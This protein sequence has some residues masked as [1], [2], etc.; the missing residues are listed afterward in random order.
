[1]S[2]N[3]DM[4]AMGPGGAGETPAQGSQG[5]GNA[6]APVPTDDLIG[7]DAATAVAELTARLGAPGAD[8]ASALD[9]GAVEAFP[10]PVAEAAYWDDSTVAA[11]MGPVGSGKTTT[12]LKS[13]LRRAMMMPRSVINGVRHYK[14]TV[15]A[16]TYRKL[17]AAAIK[18]FVDIYPKH[19]GDWSG[20]RGGPVTFVM[21]FDEG[22]WFPPRADFPED[23]EWLP[24]RVILEVEFMAFG[25]D[26]EEAIRGLQTTDVWMPE[27]D[28]SPGEV[29]DNFMTRINRH[30]KSDHK[31]GY[32]PD[33]AYYGQIVGDFNAPDP[34]NWTV[35]LL[36][37]PES[38]ARVL[39]AIN[40]ALP[41][42]AKP[43]NFSFYRQPGYGE[44]GCENLRNLAPGYYEAFIASQT[45]QGKS[46][47]IARLI[48]N[49]I[50]HRRAGE[51]VFQAE[52]N[53][54]IHIAGGALLPEPGVPLR[55]G[56]DQG[57][58]AA[59]VVAQFIGPFHWRILAE[60]HLP[61]RHMLAA[62]FGR[63]LRDLI[64]GRFPGFRVEG[65]WGDMAGEA[66]SSL[67]T[68]DVA[69]W[70]LL[71]GRAA[72]IRVRPQKVGANRIQPRLEAVRAALEYLHQG[73]PGLLID[74]SC[75]F[76]MAGFEARY[77]WTEETDASGGRRKV[78]DKR[79]TEANV[80]D[81][82][83]YLLLSEH[84]GLGASPV[85]FPQGKMALLGH[86]RGRM[87]PEPAGGLRTGFDVLNPHGG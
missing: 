18:D 21:P 19:L 30:P 38:R 5:A 81:A 66:G 78:P 72:G 43:I 53:P 36:M 87:A 61:D 40:Q 64:D 9:A 85:S 26:I 69:T 25:D 58:K 24:Q 84:R 49:R 32:P 44:P 52:F 31:K 50:T 33:Q 48:Y 39:A 16:P 42:G 47:T 34:D 57:F 65:A 29:F 86:D 41:A 83:Q 8:I 56:L 45:L 59:A 23:I 13:R 6:P 73:R 68:D 17:W 4:S 15:V 10:G 76:L 82:L 7:L 12:V 79:L 46:D 60:L 67:A 35:R 70:N 20:G 74:P 27:M 2:G 71:V 51:P 1:M 62:E 11:I 14:L 22:D 75:R 54:R 63:Q 77:V 37:D 28:T 55:I 3:L 80:M